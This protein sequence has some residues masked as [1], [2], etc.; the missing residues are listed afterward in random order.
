MIV[1]LVAMFNFYIYYTILV[2][3]RHIPTKAPF[4]IVSK[5][6]SSNKGEDRMDFETAVNR[7]EEL[8][9]ELELK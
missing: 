4:S 7:M 1:K 6:K 5:I 2:L 3:D 8:Y 9:K